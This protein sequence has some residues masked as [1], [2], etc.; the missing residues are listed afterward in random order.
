MS[1]YLAFHCRD[2]SSMVNRIANLL[3]RNGVTKGA[4][5]SIYMCGANG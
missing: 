3:L 4:V 5:V 2:L 1:P